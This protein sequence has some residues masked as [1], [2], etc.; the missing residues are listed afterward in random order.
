MQSSPEV[1]ECEGVET[2]G[3]GVFVCVAINSVDQN[4]K[5]QPQ[6][7]QPLNSAIARRRGDEE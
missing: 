7:I 5:M 1:E 3:R 4:S 2:E 6:E